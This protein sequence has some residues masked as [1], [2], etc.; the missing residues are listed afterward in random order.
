[1][2]DRF[3]TGITQM[4]YVL[5]TCRRFTS[6]SKKRIGILHVFIHKFKGI[7]FYIH[8][9]LHLELNFVSDSNVIKR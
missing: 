6:R 4:Y 7:G 1:M 5:K 8:F 2:F 3:I 9:F